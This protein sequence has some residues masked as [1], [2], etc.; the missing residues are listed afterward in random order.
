MQYTWTPSSY[1]TRLV[2]GETVLWLSVGGPDQVLDGSTA[3]GFDFASADPAPLGDACTADPCWIGWEVADIRVAA[4][5]EFADANPLAV[6]LFEVVE[7]NVAD[8]A[9]QNVRYENGENT[10][11]DV[12]RHAMDWIDSNRSLVDQW[13]DTAKAADE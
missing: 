2:P 8:I 12:E 7:L 10:G 3:G 4:N 11:A 6:A 9:T 1:L 13:L 5:K